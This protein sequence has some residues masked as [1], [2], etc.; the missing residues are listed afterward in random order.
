MTRATLDL[1]ETGF[2]C[3]DPDSF[4]SSIHGGFRNECR[5]DV[6]DARRRILQLQHGR[7][8][9]TRDESNGTV[10]QIEVL[11]DSWV[12]DLVCRWVLP[13]A[14]ATRG[15]IE[16]EMVPRGSE[17]YHQHAC[18]QLLLG[19]TQIELVGAE[20]VPPGMQAEM[21][22]RC[23]PD[24]S[25]TSGYRWIAHAR[26]IARDDERA[27]LKHIDG[28]SRPFEGHGVERRVLMRRREL[29]APIYDTQIQPH[30]RLARGT[31]CV[32]GLRAR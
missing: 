3:S 14:F 26:F 32:V 29:A 24:A 7:L 8:A 10:I 5:E 23:E 27:W 6:T 22:L 1:L 12:Y 9:Y 30:A 16:G 25:D 21:Y 19:D 17:L 2:E 15:V 4:H 28:T 20:S 18:E 11:E 13:G 31:R